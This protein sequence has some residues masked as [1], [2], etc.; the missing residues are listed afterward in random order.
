MKEKATALQLEN[1][2]RCVQDLQD[3]R[4][5]VTWY[6]TD[7]QGQISWIEKV[8]DIDRKVIG[9]SSNYEG[10]GAC[11]IWWCQYRLN[12]EMRK[13]EQKI[14]QLYEEGAKYYNPKCRTEFLDEI[15][16]AL[17]DPH[18]Q[19]VGVWGLGGG[20]TT[21]LVKQVGEQVKERGLFDAV[22]ITTIVEEPNVEQIQKDIASV[23]G[24]EFHEEPRVERRN[25]LR[26]RMKKE[27]KILILVLVD[28]IWG[29][30]NAQKIDL[31]ELGVPLGDECKLLITS[32]NLDFVKNM[33]EI[34]SKVFQLEVLL[35]DEALSLF[36]KIVGKFT[37][38]STRSLVIEIIRRCAGSTLSTFVMANAL[39]GAGLPSWHEAL[40]QLKQNVSP[41]KI[42]LDN[43]KS[44]ELK[45]LFL[46]LTIRG[47]RA[48]HKTSLL[49]DT[50]TSLLQNLG[51]LETAR[52]RLDSLITDIKAYGLVVEDGNE[53]VKIVDSIWETAYSIAQNE[54]KAEIFS[55]FD[56]IGSIT[57]GRLLPE[58]RFRILHFCSMTVFSSFQIPERL[59]CPE[60]EEIVLRTE[61]P[62]M[63]PDSFF[64]DTKLLKVLDF[65]GFDCSELPISI[66]LLKNIQVL[67]MSNCKLGDITI[68]GELANLQMLSLQGSHIQQLPRQIGQLHKLR[69]LDLRDTYLQVIPPK[70]LANL[71]SLEELYLRNSF[72]NWE[73]ERSNN[74]K[75]CASLKEL[76]N[77][78]HLTHIED[79]YVPNY[80]AW[81]VDL[82]FEKLKSYT[83][84]IGDE[85]GHTHDGDHGLK[86][87]KLKLNRMFQSEEG[88][89]KMLKVVD[90]LYLDELNGVQNVLIDLDCYGY[91]FPYLQSLVVQHNAE[92][93]CIAKSSSHS[94]DDVMFSPT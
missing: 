49:F 36:D 18:I 75:C 44:E 34:N 68:L 81:P 87:L 86:T 7:L 15:M 23:L 21:S 64:E 76:T 35:E 88:I 5:K 89:K 4:Q 77:L 9:L 53:H 24:L 25:K 82:Y 31:E 92:I 11:T 59:S 20:G 74:E 28:D 80:E 67:S 93:K 19:T 40:K 55:R 73:V 52:N 38:I 78:H 6:L 90:V 72:S 43:L 37:D 51:T 91:G 57:T 94:L 27:R 26:Q 42:F 54:L 3:K 66:G 61:H 45:Y 84:F 60:L 14:S 32:G 16:A 70:V 2:R 58:E 41:I 69:F 65:V 10:K 8:D 33:R 48:I 47:R 83:I 46:L 17:K 29:E 13:I 1:L 85:W 62:I 71:T 79:L 63:V 39:R 56:L 50:W 12:K 22:V 30:L